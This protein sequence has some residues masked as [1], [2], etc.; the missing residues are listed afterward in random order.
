[1][2]LRSEVHAFV[3]CILRENSH[4]LIVNL[5]LEIQNLYTAMYCI[6]IINIENM[7]DFV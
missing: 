7:Q 1:M 4:K 6:F 2:K 5:K 3:L